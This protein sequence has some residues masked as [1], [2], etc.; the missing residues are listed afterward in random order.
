MNHSFYF[1][2]YLASFAVFLAIDFVWLSFVATQFYADQIGFLLAPQPNIVAA[3]IF[4]A[5]FV[6]GLLYFVVVPALKI[7][8]SKVSTVALAGAF[9]GVVT[10]A[11]YEL[12]NLATI[13]NWPL[14]L[15][16]VDMIW[17]TV[18]SSSVAAMG[19]II[20]KRLLK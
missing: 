17:G 7:K 3:G 19:F 14:L 11:T 9:F 15:V 18:L 12:T 16:A 13:D 2:L 8:Q 10:Y 1:K 6:V 4:Y 5:I 20:G